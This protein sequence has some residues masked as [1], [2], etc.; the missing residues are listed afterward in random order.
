MSMLRFDLEEWKQRNDHVKESEKRYWEEREASDQWDYLI[1]EDET[2]QTY[3][4]DSSPYVWENVYKI[5]YTG[6]SWEFWNI[7]DFDIEALTSVPC[8]G[9]TRLYASA[10]RDKEC[11]E[12]VF[13]GRAEIWRSWP[14][15]RIAGDTDFNFKKDCR[16]HKYKY[17]RSLIE[18]DFKGEEKEKYICQLDWCENRHH[19]LENFSLMFTPGGMNL[20]KNSIGR[21]RIDRYI[22]WLDKYFESKDDAIFCYARKN[23][24]V[25]EE[26]LSL[27]TGINDYCKKIYKMDE[28]MVKGFLELGKKES[29]DSG[30]DVVKFMEL[31][32]R[33]WQRK[34]ELIIRE[35]LK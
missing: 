5:I 22:F 33:Y 2:F 8:N 4:P 10:T 28:S 23:K 14:R 30:Q 26:Y 27:F 6:E 11:Y 18:K 13:K 12:N 31:A 16:N 1:N 32:E 24:E 21:D 19:S 34:H 35:T 15:V 17:Y 3:D 29:F 25:L 20:F 7:F 9:I